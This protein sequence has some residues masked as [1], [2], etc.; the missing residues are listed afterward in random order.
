MR[1]II[2]AG[3][4]GAGKTTWQK[5]N[6]PTAVVCSA[7]DYFMNAGVYDFNGLLLG[8]AH[9]ECLRNFVSALQTTG[10]ARPSIV[11]VDNTNTRQVEVA[12]YIALAEAYGADIEVH[13]WGTETGVSDVPNS[14]R[15]PSGRFW[16]AVLAAR[17]AHDCPSQKCGQHLKLANQLV[18]DW[19]RFWPRLTIHQLEE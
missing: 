4:S 5:V 17:S 8:A 11:V 10:P 14:K 12:P 9:G 7:S 2:L 3:P 19:P 13:I 18:W 6:H 1:V 15:A 16:D